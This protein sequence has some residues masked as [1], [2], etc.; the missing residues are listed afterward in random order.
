MLTI[1][2]LPCHIKTNDV[3]NVKRLIPYSGDKFGW[4]S[5][6]FKVEISST[7]GGWCGLHHIGILDSIWAFKEWQ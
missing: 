5:N 1:L 6:N 3:F 2:K 7:W 4:G